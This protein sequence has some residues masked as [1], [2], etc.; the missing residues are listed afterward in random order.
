MISRCKGASGDACVN[1]H[2]AKS[3]SSIAVPDVIPRISRSSPVYSGGGDSE[4]DDFE[5][6][7][8]FA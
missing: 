5:S 3:M 2:K 6:P 4:L 1:R 7:L 8:I